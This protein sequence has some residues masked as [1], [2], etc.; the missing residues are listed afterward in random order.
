MLYLLEQRDSHPAREDPVLTWKFCHLLHKLIRDGHKSVPSESHRYFV[1]IS[2]VSQCWV[3][4]G[5]ISRHLDTGAGNEQYCKMLCERL[6]FHRKYPQIPGN[7]VVPENVL[8][9]IQNDLDGA[10]EAS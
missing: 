3:T 7:L 4:S 6:E 2:V 9:A 1:F 5:S 8:R 10:F